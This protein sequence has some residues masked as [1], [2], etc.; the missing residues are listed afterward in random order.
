MPNVVVKENHLTFGGVN[1]FRGHAEEIEIGSIGEKQ[2]PLF[3]QNYLEVK[4]R[5]L[6]PE[7]N[8]VK[9]TVVDIDFE[10]TSEI[11]FNTNVPSKVIGLPADL[12]GGVSFKNLRSG[13]LKLVKF[14]VLNN[15]MKR[16]M[17]NSPEQ[18]QDMIR[19]GN[20][21]R[22]V[23]QVFIVIE[24]A[25]ANEFSRAINVSISAG[26]KGLEAKVGGSRSVS[27]TTEVKI[28]SGTCFAYLMARIDWDEK[29]KKN[30]TKIVDLDD[31]QWG[32]A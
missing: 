9:A 14:S 7:K 26:I 13:D 18:L 30:R 31:D 25:L 21:A 22:I 2:K 16:A 23:H 27:G 10:K 32:F 11:D 1:Y 17:N 8:V 12:D 19:W 24:A 29:K 28:S 4:D 3:K 5:I 20:D 15:D 6:I